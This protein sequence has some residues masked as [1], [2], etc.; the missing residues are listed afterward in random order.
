MKCYDITIPPSVISVNVI[1]RDSENASDTITYTPGI[2]ALCSSNIPVALSSDPGIIIQPRLIPVLDCNDCLPPLPPCLDCYEIIT[3]ATSSNTFFTDC[4]GIPRSEAVDPGIYRLCSATYPTSSDP[5]T[6]ILLAPF[7]CDSGLCVTPCIAGGPP[8]CYTVTITAPTVRAFFNYCVENFSNESIS[9]NNLTT[10]T[11]IT[12]CSSTPP[13]IIF[14][15]ATI[16]NNGPCTL[17][18]VDPT[19]ICKCYRVD[20]DLTQL[21]TP[22]GTMTFGYTDC[23]DIFQIVTVTA[24]AIP[25]PICSKSNITLI[26]STGT[27]AVLNVTASTDDCNLGECI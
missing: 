23:D 27:A 7:N 2:Y 16:V 14:G 17:A 3:T 25:T 13:Q 5:S 22:T 15:G 9:Y 24:G 21:P 20:V 6:T 10:G 26:S 19:P 11:I 12:A 8:I 18:C 1:Y 4:D